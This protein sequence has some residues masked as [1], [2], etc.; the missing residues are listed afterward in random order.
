MRSSL[1]NRLPRDRRRLIVTALLAGGCLPMMC[2]AARADCQ[3]DI[4]KLMKR[5]LDA[6]ALVNKASKSVGGKLDPV[7]ACPRLKSLAS[8]EGEAT[9]YM[10]KNKDWCNLPPD[11]VD[12]MSASYSRTSSFAVKACSVAVQFKKM[13]QQQAQQQQEAAPKLPS[14]PL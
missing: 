8:V 6:V 14:G 11:F 1:P 4:N 10:Q 12:K 9:A 13:Q 5:R 3:D 7:A 2:F